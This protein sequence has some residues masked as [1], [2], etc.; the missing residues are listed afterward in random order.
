MKHLFFLVLLM[1]T[2]TAC[3]GAGDTTATDTTEPPGDT[4]TGDGWIPDDVQ[5]D[6]DLPDTGMD[7]ADDDT[8]TLG[9]MVIPPETLEPG[10]EPGEGCFLD[11]C[12]SNES[13]LSGWC[14]GHMGEDVCTLQCQTECPSG[15]GCEQ[16]PGTAPDFVWLCISRHANLCLPCATGADCKGAAGADDVCVDYGHEG[17]FCGGA[18]DMD[19]DCPWGFSCVDTQ[20]V[21]EVE[22]RQCVADAGVCPCTEKSVALALFTPCT[23]ENE[24]GVCDGKRICSAEGL[25]DCD[26]FEPASW[27]GNWCAGRGWR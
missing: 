7:T 22:T 1:T 8:P 10:C 3:A 5:P 16:V 14:V 20:T 25:S 27:A 24:A 15:W 18:C 11:P 2:L 13:C 23:L 17:S 12:E 4:I 21:D 26:A 6:H 19:E 9:D